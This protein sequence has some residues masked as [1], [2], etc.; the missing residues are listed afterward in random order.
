MRI[1]KKL[2]IAFWGF[3]LVA[4]VSVIIIIF[5]VNNMHFFTSIQREEIEGSFNKVGSYKLSDQTINNIDI[6]WGWSQG[7][8]SIIPYDGNEIQIN[9][10]ACRDLEKN[11]LLYCNVEND[12]LSVKYMQ[13]EPKADR[14][15]FS[16]VDIPAKELEIKIPKDMV[17]NIFDIAVEVSTS[18]INIKDISVKNLNIDSIDGNIELINI[19][20]NNF[21][22]V[23]TDGD[24]TLSNVNSGDLL[25]ESYS[26]AINLNNVSTDKLEIENTDGYITLSSV[27][28]GGLSCVT[29]SGDITFSGSCSEFNIKSTDGNV[30]IKDEKLPE[31]IDVD[32][33]SGNV[34]L[35]IPNEDIALNYETDSGEF[36]S[37]LPIIDKGSNN[38]YSIVTID[39]DIEIKVLQ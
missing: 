6:D 10:Y 29:Y 13:T 20:S 27:N 5:K 38:K 24:I 39:G 28:T 9:E 32:T 36:S 19:S 30:D 35:T 11:E 31:V 21:K 8:V 26:G 25:I 17:N 12:R 34:K 3:V 1:N 33:H 7:S 37:E 15:F 4:A 14:L 2:G 22:V 18:N 23:N 16:H